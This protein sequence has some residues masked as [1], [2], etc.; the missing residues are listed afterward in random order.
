MK[1]RFISAIRRAAC[2]PLVHFILLGVAVVALHRLVAPAPPSHRIVLSDA[3]VRGLRQDFLRRHGTLPTAEEE[4]ALLRR[5][6]DDEI[7]YREAIARGFDRGDIIVRRRLVQKM[8]FVLDGAE[9]IPDPTDAELQAYLESHRDRYAVPARVSLTHVFVSA[10][11]H[12]ADAEQIATRLRAQ[13]LAGA[14]P[15]GVGDPFVRGGTFVLQSEQQLSGIFGPQFAARV[16]PLGP[17]TWSAPIRSSYGWHLVRVTE[18][19]AA[20]APALTDIREAVQRD[21][22][23]ERREQA[24]RA[25]LARLRQRYEVHV[26]GAGSFA[27]GL[28]AQAEASTLP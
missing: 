5:F 6:V 9:P 18:R 2:E 13:L 17:Q 27:A 10:D 16:I 22:E 23:E 25:A 15:A 11:R 1:H 7:L 26:D 14:D 24:S 8:E 28:P 12:P 3:V 21:W 19:R 20:R 4:A